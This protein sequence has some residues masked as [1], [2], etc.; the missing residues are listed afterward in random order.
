MKLQADYTQGMLA[1]IQFR[2][3]YLSVY[4]PNTV[5]KYEKYR[6]MSLQNRTLALQNYGV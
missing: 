6:T 5:Y 1:T 3:F 2:T 4:Y